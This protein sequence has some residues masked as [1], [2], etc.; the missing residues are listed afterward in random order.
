MKQIHGAAATSLEIVKVH[1]GS[2]A[3]E[4]GLERGDRVLSIN[5]HEL[6]DVID[7]HYW[8]HEPDIIVEVEKAN[9]ER[10][11]LDI[12]K[13][14]GE[15]LGVELPPLKIKRCPNKC[16]FCFVDQMAPGLRKTLYIRDEDYRFSFLHGSYVTLTNLTKADK[17]RIADQHLSPLY[18][19]VHATDPELRRFILQNPKAP[20]VVEEMRFLVD[21]GVALHTQ[22][23]LCPGINDGEHLKKTIEDLAGLWP[24]V[25]S[26]AVVPVG[27]TWF[28]EGKH[29]IKPITPPYA[30]KILKLVERYQKR[31]RREF[32]E[33]LVYPSDEFFIKA[34]GEFPPLAYYEELPQLENGVGLVP[35][36]EKEFDATLKGCTIQASRKM[37]VALPTG[38]SFAPW[39]KK[40]AKRLSEATGIELV[41]VPVENRLF[42]PTVTVT[43]LLSSDSILAAVT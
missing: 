42:G 37:R 30:G 26:I 22:I 38:I 8:C 13:D 33:T 39:L 31:F 4:T 6:R 5:G 12:E 18:I 36:F 35:L 32:G 10:W 34:G 40:A 41:V 14:E 11:S 25:R 43:G 16:V 19:S 20:D 1:R 23:V 28:R 21:H 29:A 24:A 17:A 7:F 27:L 15:P 3:A 2:I 9:G